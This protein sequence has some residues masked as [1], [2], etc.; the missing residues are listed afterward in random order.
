MEHQTRVCADVE[1]TFTYPVL[2]E[3]DEAGLQPLAR[4]GWRKTSKALEETLELLRRGAV[5]IEYIGV[6]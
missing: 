5:R 1:P 3:T 4:E 2:V 6:F